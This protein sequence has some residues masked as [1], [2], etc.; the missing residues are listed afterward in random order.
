MLATHLLGPHLP[1]D[2]MVTTEMAMANGATLGA[3]LIGAGRHSTCCAM[4]ETPPAMGMVADSAPAPHHRPGN[5]MLMWAMRHWKEVV[6][7]GS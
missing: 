7:A 2:M 1:E 6:A 5:G 4:L 3:S